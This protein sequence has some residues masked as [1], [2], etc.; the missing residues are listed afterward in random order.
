MQTQTMSKILI[1]DDDLE[2]RE[3]L[4]E[5]LQGANYNIGTAST[6]QDGINKVKN[7]HYDIIL[8]DFM[9]PGMNGIEA[10]SEFKRVSP[11]SKVIMITAFATIDNAV[12]AIKRGASDYISKPFKIPDLLMLVRQVLEEARFENGIKKL[13]ME[14][15]L[16]SLSNSTR[17][18]ILRM[19]WESKSMRLMEITRTLGID[20]HTKVLFHLKNLKG[21]ALIRQNGNKAYLLT[22]E[23][24][25][26]IECLAILD[27]FLTDE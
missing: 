21:S 9:M 1:V 17:R 8:L 25:K 2:I 15:T 13:E 24:E 16:S 12:E 26:I 11:K 20:D 4:A 10:L 5:I 3:N 14:E 27:N 18:E 19:I 23:G 7:G 6:A 22:Q